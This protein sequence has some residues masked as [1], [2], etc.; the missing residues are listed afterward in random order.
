MNDVGALLVELRDLV[1]NRQAFGLQTPDLRTRLRAYARVQ[2]LVAR[3]TWLETDAFL[4]GRRQ[5][6]PG[7]PT[8]MDRTA[9]LPAVK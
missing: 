7:D 9:V 1:N 3:M 4:A 2:W 6:A 5:G 8:D